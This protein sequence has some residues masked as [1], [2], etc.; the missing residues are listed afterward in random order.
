MKSW[1]PYVDTPTL[2]IILTPLFFLFFVLLVCWVY[3]RGGKSEYD[4]VGHLPLADTD[5]REE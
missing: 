5:G 2:T 4:R 1:M 3:R